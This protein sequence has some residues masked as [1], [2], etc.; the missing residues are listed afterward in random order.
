MRYLAGIEKEESF[1]LIRFNPVGRGWL[2]AIGKEEYELA[3][4]QLIRFNP[5]GRGRYRINVE[6][7]E[8]GFQL[9][10]F[11]PVGRVH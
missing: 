9:I 8:Q 10:R 2:Y 4:F 7:Q 5:V 11:N 1:Q 6:E 3:S